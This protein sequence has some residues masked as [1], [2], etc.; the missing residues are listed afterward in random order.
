M[1]KLLLLITP[2]LYS[3]LS[4][5]QC[6][7]LFIENG[8]NIGADGYGAAL[9]D[10]DGDGDIDA[11]LANSIGFDNNGPL[12]GL[13][14]KV[15]LNDGAGNFTDNG[16]S[17]GNGTSLGVEL[18]DL[19]GDGDIDAFVV[20]FLDSGKVWL[21][22]GAGNF[23]GNGQSLGIYGTDVSLGDLDGDGDMDAF[24][25]STGSVFESEGFLGLYYAMEQAGNNGLPNKVWLNDGAGNFTDSGQN[26]GNG[27]SLGVDLADLDGDGDLDAFVA[28]YGMDNYI[29]SLESAGETNVIWKNDGAGNFS[30][31]Q[32][33]GTSPSYD[34]SLGDLDGDGDVDAFVANGG[35]F[36]S[37]LG[38][39]VSHPNKIWLN[40]G[41]G[42][43]FS[44]GQI[45]GE[46]YSTSISLGDIDQDGDLDAYVGNTRAPIF[47]SSPKSNRLMLNNGMGN[48]TYDGFTYGNDFTNEVQIGDLDSDGD[49]DVFT[50][51]LGSS[52]GIKVWLLNFFGT[53]NVSNTVTA[54]NSY[55]TAAGNT[56]TSS[57]IY[58]DTIS[59]TVG[60]DSVI[61]TILTISNPLVQVTSTA[62][63]C[64]QNNGEATVNVSGGIAPYSYQWV[65]GSTSAEI[66]ALTAG[67]YYVTVTDD[68]GC[69]EYGTATINDSQ[70]PVLTNLTTDLTCVG[71]NNGA[72]D[73]SVT[74]GT[75]P[76]VFEWSNGATTEDISNLQAGQYQLLVTDD[77]GCVTTE[78]ITVISPAALSFSSIVNDATC[79]NADGSITTTI[80]GGTAPYTYLWNTGSAT[81]VISTLTNGVYQLTVTDNNNCLDSVYI[82]VNEVNAPI[83]LLDSINPASCGGTGGAFVS[84]TGG[85]PFTYLWS[86]GL[87]SEDLTNEPPGIYQLEV[88]DTASCT[89]NVAITI[90][91]ELIGQQ[92]ICI[93]SVD[94]VTNTNIV[95]WSK[96]ITDEI[97]YF[98][99][100][101]EGTVA[102]QYFLVASVPYD[103]LSQYND[104]NSNPN[105]RSWRYR[106]TVL[107]T[108]GVE[109]AMGNVHR[110]MHL[111]VSAGQNYDYNL[112][113]NHYEGFSYGTYY[114]NR[115]HPSTGWELIDSIPSNLDSYTDF[116][117]PQ[118]QVFYSVEAIH[119]GGCTS[120]KAQDHNS[121]RSNRANIL[122][123]GFPPLSYF[124][125]NLTQ[126]SAG[127]SVDFT[128]QSLN[129]PTS[130]VWIFN[131]AVP[132]IATVQNPSGVIYNTPGIYDV[133]LI[134]T[135]A[136]GTDTLL[137][138]NYIVVTSG[139]I[140][141]S[142]F[143]AGTT[144]IQEGNSVNFLDLSQ[145]IPTSWTWFFDGATPNF[146]TLQSPVGIT[147]NTPGLYDVKLL[148]TNANG[149]DTLIKTNYIEVLSSAGSAPTTDF[150]AG[151]TQI[152]EGNTVD[153]LDLSQNNPTSWT[154]FFDGATPN[155]ST[156]QSP[157]GITYNTPG[158][159]DV[160]L[161]ATNANGTDTLIK[162]NYI[163]VLSSAGSAPI[164]DFIAGDTQIQEGNSVDFLD[165]CQN[166]PTAWTWLFDGGSPAF[167]INQFPSG[168]VYDT[169]G[170]YDVTL[171]ATNSFGID[172]L[173]KTGYIEVTSATSIDE[174][175]IKKLTVH[176]NPTS[177]QITIDIKGYNGGVNV[178]VYDLQGRLL[179]TTT[180]TIVSLKKHAKGIYV[181]KVSYGDITEMIRV[182]R[183]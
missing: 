100:Y 150:I 139:T 36:L 68:N 156:L 124:S 30:S 160:K 118:G 21:N 141:T 170:T 171:I 163:E 176:P 86:N 82:S 25:T 105:Q 134:S 33:L 97:S 43:F 125:G 183:D 45:L 5:T 129:D 123:G 85:G 159:Y 2:L 94:S 78:N 114:I 73:V 115:Y 96:P 142:D 64:G 175:N 122:D 87:T 179:E 49:L 119:P 117:L 39:T 182:V 112:S 23:I 165:L 110:T 61:T 181:L 157:V 88:T 143:I 140:P 116:S 77:A 8:Q 63:I 130:W 95:A 26:L 164:T 69:I 113:W 24:V 106:L 40:N 169:S 173:V 136:N 83:I 79:G 147:Y 3:T 161:L 168:I 103:S 18:A 67:L 28:N 57:G 35:Y 12:Q 29:A 53:H 75:T 81:A 6:S 59:N 10:L 4:Y 15:W 98:N 133:M 151:A 51:N 128:D 144:Q 70:G 11:F 149:T 17:L 109:S 138:P 31:F 13:P 89:S 20:N 104:L 127:G 131:G 56:Y 167:S 101:K 54:C 62:A 84:V 60:C 126:V 76:Y 172:T 52:N 99:V 137:K 22:D 180:N 108:C 58:H 44:N 93:I 120:T 71:S 92:D 27:T 178:S 91:Y 132:S 158:L 32:F 174:S 72:I 74:G 14:N 50:V 177:D 1:K 152:Q 154:W 38:T 9:A 153:F 48:F 42:L 7:T 41:I 102:N 135:N 55:T 46:S 111:S 148:A 65:N 107:D 90:D 145:N 47:I 16:Q 121:T 162:T 80:T 166:N 34:V 146:S 19:D 37:G 66:E 155:F